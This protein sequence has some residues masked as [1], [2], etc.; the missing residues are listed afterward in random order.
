MAPFSEN[1]RSTTPLVAVLDLL[2]YVRSPATTYR[3]RQVA[4][5]AG[6]PFRGSVLVAR[7]TAPRTERP[8]TVVV[9]MVS[10]MHSTA[11][12][13][14]SVDVPSGLAADSGAALPEAI[15]I[16]M[17]RPSFSFES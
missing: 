8:M 13:S 6:F 2:H 14:P 12:S 4:V 17:D 3:L 15:G 7:G 1:L 10:E 9:D 16:V 11:P 5:V